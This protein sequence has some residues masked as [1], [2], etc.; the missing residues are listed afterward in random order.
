[1]FTVKRGKHWLNRKI[2]QRSQVERPRLRDGR[3]RQVRR[4]LRT[5]AGLEGLLSAP[6]SSLSQGLRT[7][8][9]FRGVVVLIGWGSR[10]G[11]QLLLLD[12]ARREGFF[13]S[14]E[15]PYLIPH[16]NSLKQM[17]QLSLFYR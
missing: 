5:S 12:W 4:A 3:E 10:E 15:F 14:D 16:K 6:S 8:S 7:V 11:S 9:R 1:M 13:S 2:I 17:L